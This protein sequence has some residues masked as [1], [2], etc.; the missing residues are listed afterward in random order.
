MKIR[1]LFITPINDPAFSSLI[2]TVSQT[3]D[4]LLK[5]R[6]PKSAEILVQS[7]RY[8][9]TISFVILCA[10]DN[11]SGVGRFINDLCSRSLV[12]G[13]VITLASS[14]SFA[15]E[16]EEAK[17][18]QFFLH[19]VFAIL[20][21]V[22][23]IPIAEENLKHIPEEL[24][25]NIEAVRFARGIVLATSL[26]VGEQKI[27]LETKLGT[28]LDEDAFD[29]I[30]KLLK[31]PSTPDQLSHL[32][33]EVAALLRLKP[34]IFGRDIFNELQQMI[35]NL[36]PKFNQDGRQSIITRL[37][38]YNYLFKKTL[39]AQTQ[40]KNKERLSLSLKVFRRT[41]NEKKPILG[42]LVSILLSDSK[43]FFG[44]DELFDALKVVL[45]DIKSVEDSIFIDQRP[46]ERVRS[47][48]IE[49]KRDYPFTPK[50]L[51]ELR[52]KLPFEIRLRIQKALLPLFIPK[53]EEEVMK[54]LLLLAKEIKYVTD[55]PQVILSFL[56]Q[57]ELYLHF[58]II[59]AYLNKGKEIKISYEN[60]EKKS[61]GHF[62]KRYRKEGCVFEAKIEK[63]PFLRRDGTLDLFEARKAVVGQLLSQIGSFRDYNGGLIS[64]KS[65]VL[66]AL[67]KLLE[68]F[69]NGSDL[70]IE[71][72]FHSIT[73][74]FMQS[75]LSATLLKKLY[76]L[77]KDL[78]DQNSL[79]KA[80]ESKKIGDTL[81]VAIILPG[82]TA[83]QNF[84]PYLEQL[85]LPSSSLTTAQ[86]HLYGKSVL[87]IL[88]RHPEE[89]L[90]ETLKTLYHQYLDNSKNSLPI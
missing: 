74:A 80:I 90:Y 9:T 17:G 22:T 81:L 89:E 38:A 1:P 29:S 69:E 59:I 8:E 39:I 50:E 58:T 3:L 7:N 45:K 67:K 42:V 20:P 19:K 57:S 82:P 44:Q 26:P 34:E 18:E 71:N 53:N 72:F 62:R 60:V 5:G 76:L 32:T 25:L 48:F 14:Y 66:I 35:F 68:N 2:E 21:S 77:L 37:V 23:D 6:I 52:L 64:K 51:K 54:N 56:K 79:K 11:T 65:E 16:F 88:V 12:P 85:S 40:G 63:R 47:L 10:A 78:L 27:L 61:L 86:I 33:D 84:K 49:I 75:I 73:P 28:R 46:N 43:D 24:R 55:I 15:F 83:L 13:K 4:L 87:G 31:K 36:A 30:Q 70:V 41:N